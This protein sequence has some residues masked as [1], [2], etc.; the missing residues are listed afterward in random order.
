MWIRSG[1]AGA[2]SVVLSDLNQVATRVIEHGSG[3]IPHAQ[4]WLGKDDSGSQETFVFG[5][6]IVDAK[7]GVGDPIFH[8]GSFERADSWVVIGAQ[9]EFDSI[10]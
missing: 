5:L 9:E 1:R 4:W 6:N 2:V 7:H 10:R 3:D 8:E